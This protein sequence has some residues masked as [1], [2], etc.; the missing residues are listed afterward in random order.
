MKAGYFFSD[1][2]GYYEQGKFG[3]RLETVLLAIEKKDLP[4][5]K[6]ISLQLFPIQ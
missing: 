1:E 3:I 6:Y 5:G 4:Y 2:P